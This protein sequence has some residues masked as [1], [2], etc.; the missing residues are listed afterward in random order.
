MDIAYGALAQG[1]TVPAVLN[2]ANEVAVAAFL[3]GRIRFR[4]IHEISQKTIESHQSIKPRTLKQIL[5]ADQWARAF[6]Q[7]IVQQDGLAT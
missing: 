6:A 3:D 4:Q 1:G 7:E 5:K 2:A